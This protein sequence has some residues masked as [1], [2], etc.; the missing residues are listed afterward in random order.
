MLKVWILVPAIAAAASGVLTSA[1]SDE[2][3]EFIAATAFFSIAKELGNLLNG[4][5][6]EISKDE[7]FDLEFDAKQQTGL[8]DAFQGGCEA[9][10]R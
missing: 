10:H 5:G 6:V 7:I 9:E 8:R 4:T 1:A 3:T 2:D